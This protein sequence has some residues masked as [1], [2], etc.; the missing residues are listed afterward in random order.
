[1]SDPRTKKL[2]RLATALSI[3]I[4]ILVGLLF[5]KRLVYGL[6]VSS[7]PPIYASINALTAVLL[8]AGLVA[9]H[10]K[11]V[12][13]HRAIMTLCVGLSAVFLLLYTLY[14]MSAEPTPYGGEGLAKTIYY[15][16]LMSHILLS[17]AVVPL[18]LFTYVRAISGSY[19]LHRKL[20][21]VAF[22]VWWYVAASGVAVY[23]MISP[24]Y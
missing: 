3:G 2:N 12:E 7:L 20:A 22:P 13:T 19:A 23:I 17:V 1:M 24:Y 18:V 14:H 5:R 11:R 9:I 21:R 10:R 15:T 16:L 6:D 8:P 4:P